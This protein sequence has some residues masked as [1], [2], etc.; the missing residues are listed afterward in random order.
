M[1]LSV[2]NLNGN[3]FYI[4]SGT[5][6]VLTAAIY[7]TNSAGGCQ[8]AI[9]Q[10]YTTTHG[11]WSTTRPVIQ[12]NSADTTTPVIS[13][14]SPGPTEDL[15]FENLDLVVTGAYAS[16]MVYAYGVSSPGL[17]FNSIKFDETGANTSAFAAVAIEDAGASVEATFYNCEFAL[18]GQYGVQDYGGNNDG[19]IIF[20]WSY[21]HGAAACLNDGNTGNNQKWF[22]KHS[23]FANNTR[24]IYMQ[25]TGGYILSMEGNDFYDATDEAVRVNSTSLLLAEMTN[26]IVWNVGTY[27][28]YFTQAPGLNYNCQNAFGDIGTANYFGGNTA[29]AYG[30]TDVSLSASPFANPSS[31]NFALNSNSGGGALLKGA[32]WAGTLPAGIGY[33]DIGAL[34]SQGSSGSHASAYAIQQ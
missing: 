8:V 21:C 26:N 9:V 25:S 10:G 11:D 13:V 33:A 5:T 28:F 15:R 30:C 23:V 12:M 14:C 19:P 32:G 22:V 29:T 16:S 6:Y 4:Q 31:A 7:L 34:Q 18:N 27:G 3:F 1:C 20:A 24:H 17:Q 2:Q